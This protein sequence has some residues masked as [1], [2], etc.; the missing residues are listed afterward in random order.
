[1]QLGSSRR[2]LMSVQKRPFSKIV[3]EIM[4]TV[5][6]Q[7]VFCWISDFTE[8]KTQRCRVV[9]KMELYHISGVA[10]ST[11]LESSLNECTKVAILTF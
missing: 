3:L 9:N 5:R 2:S 11:K 8:L 4:D 10:V 7:F 6:K 1:M